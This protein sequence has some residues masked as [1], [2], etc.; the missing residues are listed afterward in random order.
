[1]WAYVLLS[2]STDNLTLDQGCPTSFINGLVFGLGKMSKLKSHNQ[3]L[4][5]FSKSR[6][7]DCPLVRVSVDQA[8]LL[9][10]TRIER[11]ANKNH[12][13]VAPITSINLNGARQTR[14]RVGSGKRA[15]RIT[16][17][18]KFIVRMPKKMRGDVILWWGDMLFTAEG[19]RYTTYF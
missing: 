19:K 1:M 10:R 8:V 5:S 6:V 15:S 14:D 12:G 9:W 16:T 4:K 3:N 11:S 7:T 13:S 18:L 17:C 2:G